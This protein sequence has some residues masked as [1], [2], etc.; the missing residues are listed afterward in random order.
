MP[1]V[2]DQETV[3]SMLNSQ[4]VATAIDLGIDLVKMWPLQ[5][6]QELENDAR[7]AEDLQVRFSCMMA[8]TLLKRSEQIEQSVAEAAYEGMDVIPGCDRDVMHALMSANQAYDVLSTY[9]GVN[10]AD[11]FLEA[12]RTLGIDVEDRIERGIRGVMAS[13]ARTMRDTSG[14][15][16]DD[17]VVE[18]VGLCKSVTVDRDVL[19][20]RYLASVT[21]G[22]ALLNLMC[23]DVEDQQ[24][25]AIRALPVLLYINGLREQLAVPHTFVTAEQLGYLI[26]LRDSARRFGDCKPVFANSFCPQ[27]FVATVRYLA[28]FAGQEWAEHASYLRWD[29]KKAEQEAKDED[30]RRSKEALAK[31]F[32]LTKDDSSDSADSDSGTADGADSEPRE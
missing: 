7:Y 8:Q 16:I 6:A 21:V 13:V 24:E 3:T 26:D 4:V 15:E 19:A 1:F 12:A 31:K 2:I 18:E 5:T 10:G 32:N 29:P 17:D 14:F 30:E 25:Q 20:R 9:R 22:D 11:L 27:T 23:Y 28:M